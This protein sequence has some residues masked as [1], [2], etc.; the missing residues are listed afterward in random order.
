MTLIRAHNT[1]GG[2]R[3]RHRRSNHCGEN[4]ENYKQFHRL[5]PAAQASQGELELRIRAQ[6]LVR[7]HRRICCQAR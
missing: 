2:Q 5:R 6:P 3:W 1:W 7:Q 4:E